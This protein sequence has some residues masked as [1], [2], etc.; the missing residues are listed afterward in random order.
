MFVADLRRIATTDVNIVSTE[1]HSLTTDL[2]F[3]ECTQPPDKQNE[4]LPQIAATVE[5]VE[6]RASEIVSLDDDIG[7]K[8]TRR[9]HTAA[10][11][12]TIVGFYSTTVLEGLFGEYHSSAA[13]GKQCLSGTKLAPFGD[14]Q[15]H[16]NVTD[17]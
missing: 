2:D 7:A 11:D 15:Q 16:P 3:D 13:L 8:K 1:D 6:D 5:R 4:I 12:Q 17:V 9:L 10:Y 14:W